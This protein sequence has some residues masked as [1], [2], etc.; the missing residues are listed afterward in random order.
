MKDIKEI[1]EAVK[2][3]NESLSIPQFKANTDD[4]IDLEKIIALEEKRRKALNVL[5]Y[6]AEK[7]IKGSKLCQ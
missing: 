3:V 6:V 1:E 5:V 4:T 7:V 2:I